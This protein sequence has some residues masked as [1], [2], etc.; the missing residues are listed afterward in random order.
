MSPRTGAVSS[1]GMGHYSDSDEEMSCT[2]ACADAE[3]G[4]A[5]EEN[6]QIE[7]H[8]IDSQP[9]FSATSTEGYLGPGE[10]RLFDTAIQTHHAAIFQIRHKITHDV[11]TGCLIGGNLVITNNHVIPSAEDADANGPK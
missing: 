6:V 7:P 2:T 11:G 9:P 1:L 3:S 8:Q 5:P 10:R 4:Q